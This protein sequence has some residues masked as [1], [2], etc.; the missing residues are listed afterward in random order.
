MKRDW[1]GVKGIRDILSH[2]YFDMDA[3]TIFKI[4]NEHAEELL[5]TTKKMILDINREASQ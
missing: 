4:C 1:K 2:H 3:E 5:E